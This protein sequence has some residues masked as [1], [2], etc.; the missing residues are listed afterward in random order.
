MKR[1]RTLQVL[2]GSAAA[3]TALGLWARRWPVFRPEAPA[4]FYAEGEEALVR[5]IADTIIPTRDNIG[6]TGV[7]A[8]QFVARYIEHCSEPAEQEMVKTRLAALAARARE[9]HGQPFVAC[10][11]DQRRELLMAFG[12][13]AD[14][15]EAEF[16][17]LMKTLT[18][19][20]FNTSEAV[21]VNHHGYAVMPGHYHGC[22]DAAVPA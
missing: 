14:P 20:G 16:F 12:A 1:R 13:S 5:A 18:I 19:R 11:A 3:L 7:E 8:D 17:N 4:G 9:R 21:M 10:T 22:V 2:A 15:S 6:A